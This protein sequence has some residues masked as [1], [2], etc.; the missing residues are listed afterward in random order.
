MDSLDSIKTQYQVPDALQS[1]HTAIVNGYVIEGHVPVAE[2]NRLLAEKPP[3]LGIAVAGMPVGSPGM[4][5]DG[6]ETEPF[7]VVTFDDQGEIEIYS[8]YSP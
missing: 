3:V 4:E 2:I 1:C 5:I 6:F 7:D 8:S